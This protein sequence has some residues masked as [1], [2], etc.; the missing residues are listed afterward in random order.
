M[1]A[2]DLGAVVFPDQTACL[3]NIS[4]PLQVPDHPLV[5]QTIHDALTEAMDINGLETLLRRLE[6]GA[7]K[8][9]A[10]DL[11]EPSPLSAEI[12]TANPY[13]FFD[14]VP[15]E[16]RRTRAVSARR[17]L[18]VEDT[19]KMSRISTDAIQRMRAECA[20]T[21]RDADE[22]HD[23]LVSLGCMTEQGVVHESNADA[24]L[25][26]LARDRRA[27]RV[28]VVIDPNIDRLGHA[29]TTDHSHPGALPDRFP[30]PLPRQ[31]R[32]FIVAAERWDEFHAIHP[33]ATATLQS[34]LR[35]VMSSKPTIGTRPLLNCCTRVCSPQVPCA[36]CNCLEF[37]SCR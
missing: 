23:A 30:Q 29:K 2:E 14:D 1:Q 10:C 18:S 19:A 11:T 8:I 9:T 21:I 31:E 12:L 5:Q 7:L 17:H 33:H 32:G 26:I 25:A 24:M 13:I 22:L 37:L 15:A 36:R 27:A 6:S 35:Q 3:E 4:S 20:P 34:R 16:E 28:T